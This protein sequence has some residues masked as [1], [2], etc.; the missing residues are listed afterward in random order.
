MK[1]SQ[2]F[3]KTQKQAP[4]SEISKNAQLLTRAGYIFKELAGA[5]DFLPLGL[6]VLNKIINVIRQEMD[7]LGAQ[8]VLLTSL[9]NPKNWKKSGR[10]DDETI[11]IWF[12]TELKNGNPV[13]LANTHE[14]AL[15]NL[16]K[17]H[18]ASYKDL[19]LSIYQF[20]TKFRNELRAKSGILRGREFIMKDLY[21]FSRSQ[22][23]LDD[24]YEKCKES[25]QG[26]FERLGIGSKTFVTFASGGSFSK[27]SHEF[28]TICSA[29][30]DTIFID[31]K[32]NIAINE[33]VFSPDILEELSVS[34]KDLIQ[35]KAIEVGNIFKLGTKYS[36]A[37]ELSFMDEKGKKQP[38]FMGSYGIGPGRVMGTI[39]EIWSDEKGLV[40]PSNVAPFLVHILSLDEEKKALN[41]YDQLKREGIEALLDDRQE[42]A[43]VKFAEADLI[44]IPFQVIVS[45]KNSK[46]NKIE[47][48]DRKTAES[49]FLKNSDE[50]VKFLKE[51]E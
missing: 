13:G 34:K 51:K 17:H 5:Y 50:L 36:K 7:S 39:A 10:W 33:E 37:L 15:A 12:K 23:E 25:Y 35:E 20:Q 22:K 24:F 6:R 49:N 44:G 26:I 38:V 32:K 28:Q 45:S 18:V 4:S 27:Y 31:Q 11:D 40:W 16:V 29:G 14:E 47:V 42:S 41:I 21:S 30:E 1:Q 8:E 48:K 2:L 3:S 9:Q 19:P 43:G 46:E